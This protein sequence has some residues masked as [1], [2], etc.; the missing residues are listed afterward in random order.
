MNTQLLKGV[1]WTL[2][3][4]RRPGVLLVVRS[5]HVL[6]ILKQIALLCQH[7]LCMGQSVARVLIQAIGLLGISCMHAQM[8]AACLN[9]FAR[10]SRN[11]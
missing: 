4:G 10:I 7:I 6:S 3:F 11:S 1:A 5:S 8:A 2:P 9:Q